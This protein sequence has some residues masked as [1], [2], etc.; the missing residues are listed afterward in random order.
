MFHYL[1]RLGDLDLPAT[2]S[3]GKRCQTKSDKALFTRLMIAESIL[4]HIVYE[5]TIKDAL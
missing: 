5:K 1:A 4:R 3:R 2:R